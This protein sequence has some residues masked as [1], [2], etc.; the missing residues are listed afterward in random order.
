MLSSSQPNARSW[1]EERFL[2][3]VVMVAASEEADRIVLENG[4]DTPQLLRPFAVV[5][6]NLFARI[7]DR[8]EVSVVKNFAAR[9]V[10]PECLREMDPR[11]RGEHFLSF[12]SEVSDAEFGYGEQLDIALNA[13]L[14]QTSISDPKLDTLQAS[15]LL[16]RS[17]PAWQSTFVQDYCSMVRCSYF[18]T[19]DHPVATILVAAS[20]TDTKTILE[21][22]QAQDKRAKQAREGM[23]YVDDE[24][25]T[26][27]IVVHDMSNGPPL[28]RVIHAF[29]AIQNQY[30]AQR[31]SL[32]R[33]NGVAN[34]Q[35]VTRPLDP[36]RWVQ[37]NP[38]V[39]SL[40]T[41]G[42]GKRFPRVGYQFGE[43]P[44][45]KAP[46]ITGCWLSQA[47]VDEMQSVMT[48]FLSMALFPHLDRKLR[49]LA[50]AINEKRQSTLSKMAAWF[51]SKDEAKPKTE[52]WVP[53]TDGG[54][55]KYLASSLEM[56]MRRAGDLC[57]ALRDFD[58][59]SN[60]FRMCRQELQSTLGQRDFNKYLI[61][62]AQEGI[63]LTQYFQGKL[64]LPQ[65]NLRGVGSSSSQECR[66]ETARDDYQRA[67]VHSYAF[68]S[69][70]IL[71]A[72]CRAKTPPHNEKA[73]AIAQNVLRTG[74]V[75]SNKLYTAVL[76]EMCATT[77][78]FV[79]PPLNAGANGDEGPPPTIQD[80]YP[81]RTRLRQFA[82][83]LTLAGSAYMEVGLYQMS[84][85]CYLRA[86][87]VFSRNSAVSGTSRVLIHEHVTTIIAHLYSK[88]NKP[89]K[90]IGYATTA[91][92]DGVP[93][94][95]ASMRNFPS[96]W[97]R[98]R[99]VLD[100]QGIVECPLMPVPTYEKGEVSWYLHAPRCGADEI[101]LQ[102]ELQ[103][104]VDVPEREWKVLEEGMRSHYQEKTPCTVPKYY[105][106]G[107]AGRKGH[108]SRAHQRSA[109]V[110][111][112]EAVTVMVSLSNPVGGTLQVD[113]LHVLVLTPSKLEELSSM[114]STSSTSS[115]SPSDLTFIASDTTRIHVSGEP[116]HL[117][118]NGNAQLVLRLPIHAEG[119]HLVVGLAWRIGEISGVSLFAS[120]QQLHC[121][122]KPQELLLEESLKAKGGLRVAVRD[123]SHLSVHGITA[124]AQLSVELCPP[125]PSAMRHGEIYCGVLRLTN[126]GS[127]MANHV[128]VQRS[129]ANVHLTYFPDFTAE[130]NDTAI[131][132]PLILPD[133]LRPGGMRDVRIVFYARHSDKGSASS[134][135]S[136]SSSRCF[137][138]LPILIGY[139]PHG[140][141]GTISTGTPLVGSPVAAS[142]LTAASPFAQHVRLFRMLRRV[143]VR[144]ALEVAPQ[145]C[146][147]QSRS[148]VAV[149]STIVTNRLVAGEAP[150]H[151]AR[152]TAVVP[153]RDLHMKVL[154]KGQIRPESCVLLSEQ[155]LCIAA[156]VEIVE[157]DDKTDDKEG[158]ALVA[159]PLLSLEDV[160]RSANKRS[161]LE[162]QL[163]GSL[164]QDPVARYFATHPC[165]TCGALGDYLDRGGEGMGFYLDKAGGKTAE[166]LEEQE[167]VAR[168][169]KQYG[170]QLVHF[171]AM[172]V[173]VSWF[174]EADDGQVRCGVQYVLLDILEQLAST[175]SVASALARSQHMQLC[176]SLRTLR[177]PEASARRALVLISGNAAPTLS[178]TDG[179]PEV[180]RCSV[181]VT[182]RSWSPLPLRV[183][184]DAVPSFAKARKFVSAGGA[185]TAS[186]S[187]THGNSTG[188][189]VD[190]SLE[191]GAVSYVGKTKTH[192]LLL[193]HEAYTC[194]FIAECR[195][196]GLCNL[197]TF[198]VSATGMSFADYRALMLTA[199]KGG[200]RGQ[201]STPEAILSQK[202]VHPVTI[203][204]SDVAW[205]TFV[206]L[207]EAPKRL[208]PAALT[209]GKA[210]STTTTPTA[211]HVDPL[212]ETLKTDASTSSLTSSSIRRSRG[213]SASIRKFESP[214]GKP[215][216]NT[217][218]AVSQRPPPSF[219]APAAATSPPPS[220]P[221]KVQEDA[222]ATFDVDG[223]ADVV[224]EEES[225]VLPHH[226][227]P[228]SPSQNHNHSQQVDHDAITPLRTETSDAAPKSCASIP[229]DALVQGALLA[230]VDESP[231]GSPKSF[232]GD[233]EGQEKNL[234]AEEDDNVIGDVHARP[235]LGTSVTLRGD[236]SSNLRLEATATT[237]D[238]QD[239]L[240]LHHT[241]SVAAITNTSL[242]HV[243]DIAEGLG[244]P[245]A[246][247]TTDEEGA[248]T[249]S[250]DDDEGP[251]PPPATQPAHTETTSHE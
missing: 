178:T 223:G 30:T 43:W 208:A 93:A 232:D 19:I 151:V 146:G 68:R 212:S 77:C 3:P 134:S 108:S 127:A 166:E 97:K 161:A 41:N 70:L 44:T 144:R 158:L 96:Y 216:N 2:Q 193:P 21:Q 109:Q 174:S 170:G 188:V 200:S 90:S 82:R 57:M 5:T 195:S 35:E 55:S 121:G 140:G 213:L 36:Q 83:L 49:T 245:E 237:V 250:S 145:I 56:Q 60:Y 204:G 50:N 135:S 71:Y 179:S 105:A 18:D 157:N 183:T 191:A 196:P 129:P 233:G 123:P 244:I 138:N 53:A 48:Q 15:I 88:L 163:P 217:T 133:G 159:R 165:V 6:E 10:R 164:D 94:Y 89:M 128:V 1:M 91:V 141:G 47:N 20:S 171:P 190:A 116:L 238:D 239:G 197:N 152:I 248:A 11:S 54:P 102:E 221:P 122:K 185:S 156:N 24:I 172:C 251:S 231:M 104:P 76:N 12:L 59:A 227:A 229:D 26:Y 228:K 236:P 67:A 205:L 132:R 222:E 78:L 211:A 160:V 25:L 27:V 241:P 31:C 215:I 139:A 110:P 61:A 242:C 92:V 74:A 175:A 80:D 117:P 32:L 115:T 125:L 131:E 118:P 181:S 148:G 214:I 249:M 66:L 243:P 16:Q 207:R 62:A 153:R 218:A 23:P 100:E 81:I 79:N 209:A 40:A 86:H 17:F 112:G 189:A 192:I 9:L 247:R 101:T 130:E 234:N 7:G 150:L 95:G 184:L 46:K 113:D 124:Q 120:A 52:S 58:A 33:I 176:V 29:G 202:F 162:G 4:M 72:Y 14:G 143:V 22:L 45:Q 169:Q 199:A 168:E 64:P 182:V 230:D 203:V 37:A 167:R 75:A 98:L 225:Y 224:D 149:L 155:S 240:A 69:S 119:E 142:P 186:P 210:S 180:A 226:H 114:P 219:I 84:L 111:V 107:A 198:D 201:L 63:A 220:P 147:T 28:E 73:L 103:L 173:C 8:S 137:N 85:R 106:D 65:V 38:A 42:S 39:D 206:T 13:I 99:S 34:P 194:S 126:I 235:P 154:G 51:R 187:R 246:H 136:S 87:R 177:T